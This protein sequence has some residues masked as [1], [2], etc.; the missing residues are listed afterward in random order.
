MPHPPTCSCTYV[1]IYLS[2]CGRLYT[3]TNNYTVCSGTFQLDAETGHLTV[4]IQANLDRETNTGY[5]LAVQAENDL[6]AGGTPATVSNLIGCVLAE[7]IILQSVQ[8]S[9]H[10]NINITYVYVSKK[11]LR[12]KGC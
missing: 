8:C 5:T 4:A 12:G 9:N 3:R 6:A 11:W 10:I 7:W 2:V 1:Y